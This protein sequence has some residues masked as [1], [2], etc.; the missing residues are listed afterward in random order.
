MLTVPILVATNH[1]HNRKTQ[2]GPLVPFL[3]IK[4]QEWCGMLLLPVPS[5]YPHL[6]QPVP[7][8]QPCLHQELKL[9]ESTPTIQYRFL[10]YFCPNFQFRQSMDARQTRYILSAPLG[11][12]VSFQQFWLHYGCNRSA[13][14]DLDISLEMKVVPFPVK[15]Y[16]LEIFTIAT[17]GSSL[18]KHICAHLRYSGF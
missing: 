6:I 10:S 7:S 5:L 8:P 14:L 17:P 1:Q 11:S 3:L 18:A 4:T 13:S 15:K 16:M 2:K 12:A 9:I